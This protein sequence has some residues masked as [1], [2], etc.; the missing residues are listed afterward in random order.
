M[1][2]MLANHTHRN[3]RWLPVLAAIA[4]L[5][6][7]R[8]RRRHPAWVTQPVAEPCGGEVRG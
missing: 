8:R 2:A 6:A 7:L 4:L 1:H 5:G 3:G